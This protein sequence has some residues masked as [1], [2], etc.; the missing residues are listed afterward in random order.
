MEGFSAKNILTKICFSK[1]LFSNQYFL[2]TSLQKQSI[3]NKYFSIFLTKLPLLLSG[4]GLVIG[5]WSINDTILMMSML[6]FPTPVVWEG[7]QAATIYGLVRDLRPSDQVISCP[8]NMDFHR[9]LTR[10]LD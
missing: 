4:H 3:F 5:Y 1:V 9:Q 6:L 7:G 10:V 8:D 2:Q